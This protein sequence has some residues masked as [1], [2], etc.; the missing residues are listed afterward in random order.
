MKFAMYCL[1]ASCVYGAEM[2]V[3][4]MV[5]DFEGERLTVYVD[6]LGNPTIGVGFNL[7]RKDARDRL[8]AVG[9]DYEAILAGSA[10]LTPRQSQELFEF[11][12]AE[13]TAMARSIFLTFDQQH[14]EVQAILI[15]M[16]YN[17]GSRLRQFTKFRRAINSMDYVA[18]ANALVDSKWYRQV[19]RR[20][21]HHVSVLLLRGV[22]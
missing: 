18:A 13:A 8:T 21:E 5:K 14:E 16:S 4:Q 2:D 11:C 19:G 20:S 22:E 6:S 1:A 7:R 9:A 15:D 12:L 10:S 3:A 17:L